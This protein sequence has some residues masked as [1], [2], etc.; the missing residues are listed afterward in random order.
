MT[1]RERVL[2][3]MRRKKPDKTPYFLDYGSFAPQ[4]MDTFK[5]ETQSDNPAEYFGY[6]LRILSFA[7]TMRKEKFDGYI[8]QTLPEGAIINPEW[9]NVEI[10][11]AHANIS[12]VVYH[13]L[14]QAKD[15]ADIDRYPMPDFLEPY[16]HRHLAD[17]N[18]AL[19]ARGYATLGFMSQTLFETS[20]ILCGFEKFLTGMVEDDPL[21]DRLL[22]RL[23][24][25]RIKQA[26]I[27]AVAGV[28]ILR[29]GDDVGTERGM[30]ISPGQFR[31]KL[32]PRY[33]RII[34][35]ARRV[36][37]DIL[38]FY[39]SD[40]DCRQIIPDLIEIGVEILN[41]VQP[42]CMDPAEIK[43]QYGKDLA[44]IGTI[45]TQRTMP[46]GTPDEVR[47]EVRHRIE[48]VGY[49]GGLLLSP[50]H[51]LQDEVPWENVLAFFD[52]IETYG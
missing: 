32:K 20:W 3:A 21:V 50:S 35:A 10:A 1:P 45:S 19:H 49:D 27:Y 18:R 4:L 28:D 51:L 7:S 36:K 42:E 37:P 13:V 26:E 33:A 5:S 41:P 43:R 30:M 25:L 24:A 39:H 14:S 40:G 15:A 34:A 29:I 16:R 17:Q 38:I 9:G 46:F 12:Q 44:F 31:E 48:T 52:A 6:S 22:D 8:P 23:E 47:D 2:T 11:G